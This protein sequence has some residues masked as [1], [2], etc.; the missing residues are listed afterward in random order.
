MNK[1]TVII[2]TF[3]RNELLAFGLK[4]LSRQE[5]RHEIDIL[6]VDDGTGGKGTEKI[7]AKYRADYLFTGQRNADKPDWRSWGIALN[8][9]VEHIATEN[10]VMCGPE[11]YYMT[12]LCL[13]KLLEPLD[14]DSKAMCIPY[15]RD[16]KGTCLDR[17]KQGKG[18]TGLWDGMPILNNKIGFCM[19]FKHKHYV[20]IGGCD[21]DFA[22]G[23]GWDDQDLVGRFLAY[24]LRYVQTHARA[25]HLYH[26]RNIP[27]KTSKTLNRPLYE[28]RRGQIYRN[29]AKPV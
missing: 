10:M 12:Y 7:A 19:A 9:G 25:V 11:M 18:I 2:T 14:K 17:L 22:K 24:G 1:T 20:D 29:G 4:S 3:D 5:V 15:A 27:S 6:V 21:D 28:S 8:R 23:R 16:D 13:A 26:S